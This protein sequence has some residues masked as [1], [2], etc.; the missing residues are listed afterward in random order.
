MGILKAMP[1]ALGKV[2]VPD[3][4][5]Q[6]R[7]DLLDVRCGPIHKKRRSP[8]MA[9]DGVG[10]RNLRPLDPN[11]VGSQGADAWPPRTP[12][13]LQIYGPSSRIEQR[14][15]DTVVSNGVARTRPQ[16][17]HRQSRGRGRRRPRSP[18]PIPPLPIRCPSPILAR[19]P[20]SLSLLL[21]DPQP[22]KAKLS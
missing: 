6:N 10:R 2:R 3:L 18:L 4:S 16:L 17:S 5:D 9:R 8:P 14:Q 20:P 12:F 19:R 7:R 15:P 21:A 22:K 11:A 1:V 13:N